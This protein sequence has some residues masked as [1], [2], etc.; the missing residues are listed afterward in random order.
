MKELDNFRYRVEDTLRSVTTATVKEYRT[1]ELKQEILNS[2]K[3]KSFFS[4]N[5]NDLKVR[6]NY[7][8]YVYIY[9]CIYFII[10][11]FNI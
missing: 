9:L 5:P 3:L 11:I 7:F 1:A 2:T 4:E 8:I 10:I 6:N